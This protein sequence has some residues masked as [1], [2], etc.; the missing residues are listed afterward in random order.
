MSGNKLIEVEHHNNYFVITTIRDGVLKYI[1]KDWY[2]KHAYQYTIKI[3][4]ARKFRT[5]AMAQKFMNL[6]N[7][8]GNIIECEI[9]EKVNN[10]E[11]IKNMTI[12]E[13]DLV[14]GHRYVDVN[15]HVFTFIGKCERILVKDISGNV[16][17]DII[18]DC[19]IYLDTNDCDIIFSKSFPKEF[20]ALSKHLFRKSSRQLVFDIGVNT[21]FRVSKDEKCV[22]V[23]SDS[24]YVIQFFRK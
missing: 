1:S 17:E 2:K 24:G 18:R 22:D 12:S 15:N 7:L 11:E 10:K 8:N 14:A 19:Y 5:I 6:F 13:K 4:K 16:F 23:L 21:R 9:I 3:H 20:P